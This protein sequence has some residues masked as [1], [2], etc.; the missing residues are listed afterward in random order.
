MQAM[1]KQNLVLIAMQIMTVSAISVIILLLTATTQQPVIYRQPAQSAVQQQVINSVIAS[2]ITYQTETQPAQTAKCDR[3]NVTDTVTDADSAL[4]HSFTNYV[5]DGNATCTEDGTKTAKCDRCEVTDTVTDT[6]SA[7]GHSHSD[8]VTQPTCQTQGYTTHTC[9]ACGDSYVDDYVEPVDHKYETYIGN[10][11]ATCQ[12]N[13]T[14][15][16]ECAFDC[17]K[18]DTREIADSKVDHKYESYVGNN[19]ATCQK[20]ETETAECAFGCGAKDTREIADS[21]VNHKYETYVGNDDATCQKNET[22]TAECAFGCGETN[23]RDI[24]NSK[25]DHKYETYIGNDDATCQKNATETAECSFGCGETNTRDIENSKVDHKFE[26]YV[27]N[28]N[29]TCQ[30]NATETADCAFG[31]GAKDTREIADSKVDHKYETYVS[32]DDATCQKNE[33]ETAECEFGCGKT[34]TRE[35]ADSKVDHKFESYVGNNNATC[36]KNETE[37]AEC[38][39]GCGTEDTREIADST[40]DHKFTNYVSDNN[41]T[42]TDDGTKTALCDYGCGTKDTLN[43][44]GTATDHD[45]DTTK[46]EENLTR[47]V[48]NADGTWSDGYYT[49]KCKNNSVHEIK[50]TVKRADYTAYDAAVEN[51]KEL[52]N[53]DITD[54]AKAVIEKALED[55]AVNDNLIET[56]QSAVNEA[57]A[58]LEEVFSQ[59]SGSLNSYSVTFKYG[60]GKETTVTVISGKAATAPTDTAKSYD[61]ANHYTFTGWDKAFTN[62]TENLIV[63][64][65]YDGESHDLSAHAYKDATYHTDSC[66]CGYSKDETHTE[67][68]SADCNNPAYCGVCSSSYGEK[69]GHSYSGVVTEP[70]CSAEGYTTYTCS[71]CGDSYVGDY[72]ETV[73]HKYETYVGNDDA[74]CQKNATETA[75]CEFACGAEDTRE[76]ANSTVDHKFQS[77]VGN[78]DATCLKNETETAECAFGCGETNTRE[79][80]NSKVDHKFESYVSNNDATCQKNATETAECAFGCGE[81]DTREIANSTVDHKFTNYVSDNNAT[82]EKDGTKTALCDYGC[83]TKDTLNDEGSKLAHTEAT[84]KENI[85]SASCGED[86]SYDLVTYCSACGSVIE[87]VTVV[88][89]STGEHVYATEV[90]RVEANC[91]EDGYVITACACGAEKTEVLASSG[92]AMTYH[93]KVD[94]TCG[95][96]GTKEFWSCSKCSTKFADENG[97]AKIDDIVIPATGNHN[98]T[99]DDYKVIVEPTCNSTGS[100]AY[101]CLDCAAVK[102]PYVEI[103][104]VAHSYG[105]WKVVKEATCSEAGEKER[106]CTVCEKLSEE[107]RPADY[108][109]KATISATGEH[110]YENVWTN[111]G[112]VHSRV[113]SVCASENSKETADHSYGEWVVTKKATCKETGLK[114][115][116]CSC[117]AEKTEVIEKSENH[118]FKIIPGYAATCTSTGLTDA[119]ECILCGFK[120]ESQTI[121]VNDGAHTDKNGDGYCDGCN[122]EYHSH[123]GCICH[124]D[125]IFS[126]IIRLICTI[127]S[128]IAR[129]R[130]TCCSDMEWYPGINMSFLS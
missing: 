36:Q 81:T 83:G 128:W 61:E 2:Q 123:D 37:T 107:E 106:V 100:K 129:T 67:T 95:K 84:R 40:V 75:K 35:I 113:C 39:F 74:T 57:T 105:E 30:K 20:N 86:G 101:Y 44:E 122:Y 15:T 118:N 111:E 93:E 124:S 65:Q 120:V 91:T 10:D 58:K 53:T 85:V 96:N 29:A 110:T 80:E 56:E 48:Q 22:E 104:M 12:K 16:A 55:N 112:D 14:E 28:N 127:F 52:L 18:T 69:K 4:D 32:N 109:E 19:D 38:A 1:Q 77:Y 117:G 88:V 51:L 90:E 114:V 70:T 64:A 21:T 45:Y 99:T 108:V 23:T 121:P 68:T 98:F 59:N 72:V 103:P 7:L 62:V 31:C 9:S 25:V 33:T 87:K 115:R 42:C 89:P 97:D 41:A 119:Y 54:E 73:D 66:A 92:H 5:S 94:A 125:N 11:D 24:E 71:A 60:D 6:D 79:I 82:C 8:V 3:C 47:P 34:D 27:S 116:K 126:K 49:F 26:S 43:D 130:I 78:D 63:T 17:G 13:E 50:E 76:I 46:S 102:S